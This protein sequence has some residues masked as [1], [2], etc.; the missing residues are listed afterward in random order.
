MKEKT[1]NNTLKHCLYLNKKP[2]LPKQ[3][4]FYHKINIYNKYNHDLK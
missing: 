1:K 2:V 3:I 4:I